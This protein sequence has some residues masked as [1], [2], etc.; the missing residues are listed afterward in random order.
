MGNN[1]Q[2]AIDLSK[3]IT[4]QH[5]LVF[6]GLVFI[7]CVFFTGLA[8]MER[9]TQELIGDQTTLLKNVSEQLS[10]IKEINN[11]VMGAH[12]KSISEQLSELTNKGEKDE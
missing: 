1:T 5:L 7:A 10:E 9:E 12:H 8:R 3:P 11:L 6:F 2:N 4:E